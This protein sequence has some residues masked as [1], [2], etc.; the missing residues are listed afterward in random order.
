MK[1]R[2][3]G[4]CGMLGLLTSCAS[5]IEGTDQVVGFQVSPNTATCS[6]TQKGELLGTLKNGGGQLDVPKS[7]TDLTVDCQAPGHERQVVKL[8][9]SPSGWGI[10]GC[11]IDLCI[12]DYST[13]ALNSYDEDVSIALRTATAAAPAATQPQAPAQATPHA[14]QQPQQVAGRPQPG[15]RITPPPA[16]HSG[17]A[18]TPTRVSVAPPQVWK[19]V[20]SRI[21]AYWGPDA[22]RD[23]FEMPDSVPLSLLRRQHHWGL[24]EYVARN[25]QRGQV[26]IALHEVKSA[27]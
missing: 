11:L 21:R 14:Q 13:G 5:I 12:T 6:V 8:E 1:L 4:L 15:A 2:V 20:H 23:F 26:W 3:I 25:G 7:H 27:R 22:T 18:L 16:T 19:T 24:F 9:S 10:A 17:P